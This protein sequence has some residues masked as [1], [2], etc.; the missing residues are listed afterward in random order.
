VGLTPVQ[1][2]WRQTKIDNELF[3]G[4]AYHRVYRCPVGSLATDLA[5]LTLGKALPVAEGGVS[6]ANVGDP[7][8]VFPVKCR[9]K[10]EGGQV[11]IDAV[12]VQID[13]SGTAGT[14]NETTKSRR[15]TTYDNGERMTIIA[16]ATTLTDASIPARGYTE[17]AAL[18]TAATDWCCASVQKTP[19]WEGGR[20]LIVAEFIKTRLE[21]S[22]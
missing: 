13:V 20:V 11:T 2:E 17:A 16:I 7:R 8:L 10:G 3:T 22:N 6:T 12:Y 18:P 1:S 15:S 19:A 9:E 5:T 14:Y 4:T 21:A